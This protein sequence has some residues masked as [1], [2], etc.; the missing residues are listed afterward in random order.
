MS[1]FSD[2]K[3]ILNLGSLFNKIACLRS[4][5]YDKEIELEQSARPKKKKVAKKVAKKPKKKKVAKKVAKKA[6]P[7]KKAGIK[8]RDAKKAIIVERLRAAE[9]GDRGKTSLDH[10]AHKT[11]VQETEEERDLEENQWIEEFRKQE[12]LKEEEEDQW[13]EEFRKQEA[14]KEEEYLKEKNDIGEAVGYS[15]DKTNEYGIGLNE[16]E[17]REF[18]GNIGKEKIKSEND[19]EERDFGEDMSEERWLE[20]LRRHEQQ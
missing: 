11:C 12:A 13:I 17:F 10:N 7:I 5:K 4:T 1:S 19:K 3:Y 18:L 20:T 6:A 14:L 8:K 9:R 16:T 15:K 2:N